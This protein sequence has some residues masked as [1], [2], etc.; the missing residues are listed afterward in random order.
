MKCNA[1]ESKLV[2]E[3]NLIFNETNKEQVRIYNIDNDLEFT[4]IINV[5]C[6]SLFADFGGCTNL[7]D[8]FD[9]K[10]STWL[11]K[12]YLKCVS[13]II[14]DSGGIISAFEGDALMGLFVGSSKEIKAVQCAFKIQWAVVNIIQPMIDKLYSEKNYK[15]AQVVGIDSSDLSAIKTKVWNHYDILWVGRSVNYSA[16]LTQYNNENYSTYITSD[17]YSKLSEELLSN[18]G[19]ILWELM[20]DRVNNVD[21]YRSFKMASL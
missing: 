5:E 14:T 9:N 12:S 18:D 20:E 16:N 19:D 21:I 3:I 8:K 4:N 13:L 2:D 7:I 11:L 10:F 15:M 1:L 6:A 17:V